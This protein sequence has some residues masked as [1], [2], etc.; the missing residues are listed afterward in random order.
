MH[1]N[2]IVITTVNF[3]SGMLVIVIYHSQLEASKEAS[4]ISRY[5]IITKFSIICLFVRCI[6]SYDLLLS[7]SS[8]HFLSLCLSFRFICEVVVLCLLDLSPS[9]LFQFLYIYIYIYIYMY[10]SQREQ[11]VMPSSQFMHRSQSFWFQFS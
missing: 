10:I 1:S 11:F 9:L 2:F 6:C 3:L 7:Y 4:K 5:I 8:S